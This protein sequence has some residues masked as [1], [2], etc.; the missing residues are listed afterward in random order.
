VFTFIEE[1]NIP[2]PVQ[3][4]PILAAL[5]SEESTNGAPVACKGICARWK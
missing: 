2:T 5:K 1:P 4:Q 3:L